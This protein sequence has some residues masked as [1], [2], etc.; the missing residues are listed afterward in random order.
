[1]RYALVQ[2]HIMGLLK[3][4]REVLELDD[5]MVATEKKS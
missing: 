2:E 1:M 4:G 3:G 5:L